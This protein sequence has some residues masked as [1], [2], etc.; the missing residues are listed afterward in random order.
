MS[1]LGEEK[2]THEEENDTKEINILLLGET[3]VGKSTFI[4]SVA[5]Y[6]THDS[7]ESA[8]KEDLTV[9]IPST[10]NITDKRSKKHRIKVGIEDKNEFLETG[11][12]AT[13]DVK[14]YAFPVFGGHVKV[15]L[16]DTPGMGDTR[17][18][19]QDDANSENILDYIGNLKELHAICFLLKP[20]NPRLTVFFKYCIS[21]IFSRL[22]KSARRNI[23]FVFTNTRGSDYGAGDT[24]SVLQKFVDYLKKKKPYVTIPI[25]RNVFCFDNEP[26]RYLAAVKKDV[27]FSGKLRERTIESWE[28]SSNE[29]KR[30]IIYIVGDD[31]NPPLKP[32]RVQN[33]T[34]INEARRMII[35]LSQ[36]LAEI[37]QLV[38]H[39]MRILQ[40]H[41]ENLQLENQNV[42]ALKKK[43]YMPVITLEVIEISQPV[44]VC[45]SRQCSEIYKV[46]E[47]NKWHYKQRCHDPCYL[48]T[49]PKEL[50]GSKELMHCA[51]INSSG[52]CDQCSC[53]FQ[54]HMHMYYMT[55]TKEVQEKDA[56]VEQN[57]KNKEELLLRVEKLIENIEIKKEEL[58]NEHHLINTICARFAH[59]LQNNA[60]T[61]FSDSYKEYI[62]YLINQEKS[63]G[64]FSNEETIDHLDKLLRE[65]EEMKHSF[66]EA[67]KNSKTYVAIT[68]G[69]IES[70][71]NDLFKLKH[72]GERIRKLYQCQNKTRSKE[73]RNEE[74]VYA[75]PNKKRESSWFLK[76]R[77]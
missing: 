34:A 25:D 56:N 65:Y 33:T 12:S 31:E 69:D 45:T 57:I 13:Q 22:D 8:E 1:S 7:F 36:P 63:L 47:R 52:N 58:E 4:N 53:S 50:I 11:V 70:S 48:K 15:R 44:T 17:G 66:D 39:N 62:E 60:I 30:M 64:E 73:F 49:V 6:L 23:I 71:I 10:F 72:N 24:I 28:I 46:G 29:L 59:F 14:T 2:M 26:F 67:L 74:Y 41:Q 32:H 77:K 40:R 42:K 20:N 68:P 43:L 19:V 51:A 35:Q 76:T 3:G 5:N 75:V 37:A 38:N 16:I 55:E 21:Q 18:I 27:E 9:L 54:V 61:P